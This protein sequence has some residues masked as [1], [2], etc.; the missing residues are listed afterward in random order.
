MAE[1]AVRPD[2][3]DQEPF[4]L[5]PAVQLLA[6]HWLTPGAVLLEDEAGELRHP[7]RARVAPTLVQLAPELEE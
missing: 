4:L 6:E 5:V 7:G 2:Q 3:L 1:E